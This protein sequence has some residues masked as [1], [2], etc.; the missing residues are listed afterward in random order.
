[1]RQSRQKPED[2]IVFFGLIKTETFLFGQVMQLGRRNHGCISAFIIRL[3]LLLYL[4]C[5]GMVGSRG[6]KPGARGIAVRKASTSPS[7]NVSIMNPRR[8]PTAELP[9]L[10][11]Y[12][13]NFFSSSAFQ[14]P[15]NALAISL[16]PPTY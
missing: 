4:P 16:T 3:H 6:E 5:F 9:I 1:M 11:V 10:A 14:E 2:D 7:P 13:L 15:V 8:L 12:F